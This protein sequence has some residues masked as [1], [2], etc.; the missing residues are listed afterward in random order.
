MNIQEFTQLAEESS[1]F[2]YNVAYRMIGNHHDAEE[3]AQEAFISAYRG[4]ESFRGDAQPSTWLYR[5]T[6]NAAVMRIRKDKLRKARTV[7]EDERPDAPSNDSTQVPAA[8]AINC[9]LGERIKQAIE[10]LPPNLKSAVVLRDVQGLTNCEAAYILEISVSALK[11]RLHRAR[12]V[13]RGVLSEY[14][15]QREVT[16]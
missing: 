4:R 9:E 8:S 14:R 1:Q 16:V 11:A 10:R 12:V 2:V 13:L 15:A 3:V 6:V 5:I 7:A